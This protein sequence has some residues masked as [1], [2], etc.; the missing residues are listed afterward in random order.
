MRD[1]SIFTCWFFLIVLSPVSCASETAEFVQAHRLTE[2]VDENGMAAI[3]TPPLWNESI[4]SDAFGQTVREDNPPNASPAPG[5]SSAFKPERE[6]SYKTI[7][8]MTNTINSKEPFI[9]SAMLE[10]AE[11]PDQVF[12]ELRKMGLDTAGPILRL[13]LD[14]RAPHGFPEG[15]AHH[16]EAEI[17][18]RAARALVSLADPLV[19]PVLRA[20][21]QAAAEEPGGRLD[22]KKDRLAA[23]AIR[24]LAELHD[25]KAVPLLERMLKASPETSQFYRGIAYALGKI[26]PVQLKG[27]L[28]ELLTD[29]RTGYNTKCQIAARLVEF[30]DDIGRQFLFE[31]YSLYLQSL[32]SSSGLRGYADAREVLVYLGDSKLMSQLKALDPTLPHQMMK[33]NLRAVLSEMQVSALSL[34]EIRSIAA[35][36]VNTKRLHAVRLLALRGDVASL[37]FLLTLRDGL[38]TGSEVDEFF[39]EAIDEAILGLRRRHWEKQGVLERPVDGEQRN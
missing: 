28:I 38:T 6:T 32:E 13:L 3:V 34:E 16:R 24:G 25:V 23:E 36:E 18:T 9:T 27:T 22:S 35:D 4:S 21:L 1:R 8:N 2:Y 31:N 12:S 20:W 14:F 10:R 17:Q 37:K 29:E 33:N 19:V 15:M 26:A 5:Q 11:I 30:D 39:R 7:L